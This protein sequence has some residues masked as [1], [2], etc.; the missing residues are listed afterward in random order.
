[1]SDNGL[2]H[3]GVGVDVA[4]A[5]AVALGKRAL[6]EARKPSMRAIWEAAEA[7]VPY[8]GAK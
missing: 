7:A 6:E 4:E 8:D 3:V 1:M 2:D 5:D